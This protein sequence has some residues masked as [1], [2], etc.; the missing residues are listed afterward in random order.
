MSGNSEVKNAEDF[1]DV[2][3][4]WFSK[5]IEAC[6]HEESISVSVFFSNSL[7]NSGGKNFSTYF[8]PSKGA[9]IRLDAFKILSEVTTS[10]DS[11]I[12]WNHK[13]KDIVQNFSLSVV[14]LVDEFTNELPELRVTSYDY[15]V[16]LYF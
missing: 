1:V 13:R 2:E 4:R 8:L 11:L 9:E 12:S 14:H 5:T 6:S 7:G 16:M 15:S 10:R 3:S